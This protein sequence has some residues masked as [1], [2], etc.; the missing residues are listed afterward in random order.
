MAVM[1][2]TSYSESSTG[3]S[4]SGLPA[5]PA[6]TLVSGASSRG[7]LRIRRLVFICVLDAEG[8]HVGPAADRSGLAADVQGVGIEDEVGT[9]LAVTDQ[10]PE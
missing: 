6:I 2:S 9:S 3:I 8:S 10:P 5:E 4:A 7:E 1:K